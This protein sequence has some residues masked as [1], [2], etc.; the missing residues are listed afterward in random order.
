MSAIGTR[1]HLRLFL[2]GVEIPI[3]AA[4]ITSQK[5]APCSASLQIPANDY[6]LDLKPRTLVHLFCY[7]GYRG[8]P[9][10]SQVWVGGAGVTVKQQLA[11]DPAKQ[12]P[13]P[14][15]ATP[16]PS[17][18]LS[19]IDLE[20]QNYKL[21]FGGEVIALSYNKSP[22]SRG[23]TLQC[24]DWSSYWDI[25]YQYQVSGMSLGH[26]TLNQAFTGASATVFN[27]FLKTPGD[28]VLNLLSTPP[29]SYP[30]L[31]GSL[32]GGLMHIIEAIGGCYFGSRAVKGTN[33]FFS[34]AEMRLHLTQM[35][36]ANPRSAK[37][38]IRLMQ[39]HGFGSLF[40]KTLGGLG[41]LVTIRQVLLALQRYIFHEIIPINAP[42]YVA[43]KSDPQGGMTERVALASDPATAALV[44]SAQDIKQKVLQLKAKQE[45]AI[46]A[47]VGEGV[48]GQLPEIS[49]LQQQA[50][51]SYRQARKL[52]LTTGAAATGGLNQ[53]VVAFETAARQFAQLVRVVQEPGYQTF[54]YPPVGTPEANR[55]LGLLAAIERAMDRVA[56]SY[57]TRPARKAQR[58]SDPPPRLLT[59]LY[60]PDVWMV[61]PPRCNVIFPELYSGFSY[62][63][64]FLGEVTRMLLRTHEAF[65]G[66]D[67]LFDGHYMAPSRILGSRSNK[68]MARGRMDYEP[69]DLS[70]APASVLKDLMD[71]ELYTGITP[72]FERMS[73]LN[74]HAIR[75]GSIE[76]DGAKVGY[77]QLACNH[78]FFQYRFKSRELMVQGKFNPYAVLGFPSVVIDKYMADDQ[79]RGGYDDKLAKRLAT[80][81]ANLPPRQDQNMIEIDAAK[82]RTLAADVMT[83]RE[84]TH[85]LGT[86]ELISHSLSSAAGGSTS[87]QMAYA[88]TTSERTEFFGDN[89]VQ[90]GKSKRKGSS[91]PP[92][93]VAAL[94]AP[95]VGSTG[96]RG[97][98]IISVENVT[99]RY[100]RA[101]PK[102]KRGQQLPSSKTYLPVFIGDN[103]VG[104]RRARG[105]RVPVGVDLE[106]S[107]YG[108]EV[109]A[110]AGSGGTTVSSD[111]SRKVTVRFEAY[112][113]VEEVGRYTTEDVK[114]PPEHLL[115]PPWYG[116]D[117]RTNKIGALYSDFFGVGAVTDPTVVLGRVSKKPDEDNER[118]LVLDDPEAI[119]EAVLGPSRLDG[120]SDTPDVLEPSGG[121]TYGPLKEGDQAEVL[122]E[123]EGRSPLAEAIAELVRI[124]SA[125]RQ[126]HYDTPAFIHNYT[127]RPIATM[128]DLFGTADLNITERGIVT[129]GRE[130]FHSRAFGDH[131]DLRQLVTQDEHGPQKILGIE[132][133]PSELSSD[134]ADAAKKVAERMD[135]RK[136]KRLAVFRYLTAL[137]ASRGVLLG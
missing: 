30:E 10:E 11:V 82:V 94:E 98:K 77:A 48:Y 100:K 46:H 66:S 75:G 42:R 31:K 112:R 19:A 14:T 125:T 78:I 1:L 83:E 24:V 79:L 8:A 33:D 85:Y 37:D 104:G 111:N 89:L 59:Q 127:W 60:R 69:P 64:N 34:L 38:E 76:I 92:S 88:R 21:I 121:G 124:Y 44:K 4:S 114:L 137:S 133:A 29:R 51:E 129:A 73:D 108:P 99:D 101:Q 17:P 32:L 52:G 13:V 110:I 58:Q 61:A 50:D 22:M 95:V 16:A 47:F 128:V 120:P 28:V 15:T 18:E 56:G 93:I 107:A 2:E 131:D 7:D 134:K 39:A 74:L 72:T 23:V 54:E 106:P 62:G 53:A 80:A 135:T 6:A 103:T 43:P 132:A 27:E 49:K 109:I 5:N 70:D 116:E 57:Y 63:R 20:N 97:G 65:Y 117:Y 71:H 119:F 26:G 45:S 115:F 81:F 91:K 126:H 130:G 3:V 25:A 12:G 123:V 40:G 68:K 67:M 136:E 96:V 36:G 122:G 41:Q 113:I 105:T 102:V 9:P 35:I 118:A 84:M 86:P 90:S 87:Y 55:V